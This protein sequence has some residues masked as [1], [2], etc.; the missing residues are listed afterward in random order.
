M[1]RKKILIQIRGTEIKFYY[2]FL[3]GDK[4]RHNRLSHRPSTTRCTQQMHLYSMRHQLPCP[5]Y[6]VLPVS[7][8]EVVEGNSSRAHRRI[9]ANTDD[10]RCLF[11]DCSPLPS[12]PFTRCSKIASRSCKTA[13]TMRR[14]R[15]GK[16]CKIVAII[17]TMI[18]EIYSWKRFLAENDGK[19]LIFDL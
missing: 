15:N 8:N 5:K 1:L 7:L 3:L 6:K 2:P 11:V 14:C 19:I 9:V 16:T 4:I 17:I 18:N 13:V 10:A 12:L